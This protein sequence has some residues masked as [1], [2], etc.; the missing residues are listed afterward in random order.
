L[1][2]KLGLKA[3]LA[4]WFNEGWSFIYSASEV[5]R[6]EFP[7]LRFDGKRSSIDRK[8]IDGSHWLQFGP[9]WTNNLLLR[10]W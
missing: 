9:S 1:S 7:D 3:I 10:G 2:R 5:G 6:E 8:E 4:P